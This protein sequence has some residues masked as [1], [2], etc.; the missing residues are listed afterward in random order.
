MVNGQDKMNISSSNLI[1]FWYRVAQ[2]SKKSGHKAW[3]L[4]FKL[5]KLIVNILY[6]L[7]SLNTSKY[8]V[9]DASDIIISLTSYPDRINTVY[10]TICTLL[11][12]TYRPKKIV[13]WLAREQFPSKKLP[14]NLQRLEKFG[15]EIR[16][17]DD[18]KSHKK[19][20]YTMQE[21]P[22]N[23]VVTVDDDM[24]Y[25]D[26][27]LYRLHQCHL[28]YPDTIICHWSHEIE[29]RDDQSIGPYNTWKNGK[30]K[31]PS[32]RTLPVG[33]NGI[34]Y[35]ADS[36]AREAFDKEKIIRYAL[37]ADDLWLKC[38]TVKNGK[39]SI[40][41]DIDPLIYFNNIRNQ[42]GSGLWKI[43]TAETGCNNDKVWNNLMC[44]YPEVELRIRKGIEV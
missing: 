12:Q 25:P 42:S 43:N 28:M 40:N 8:G 7:Y 11:E 33:C 44:L 15:L 32:Y 5:G 22:E 39:K 17:C 3:P 29:Y 14:K 30:R 23:I 35:P 4:L 34:L 20:F 36:L 13:L 18:L 38:M 37:T 27:F 2:N 1:T 9:N 19:Y 6:P 41:C 31:T 16:Y 21:Y 26:D 10:I 24:F